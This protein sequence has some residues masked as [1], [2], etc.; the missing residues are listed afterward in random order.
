M[1][2]CGF[3]L[4]RQIRSIQV[5]SGGVYPGQSGDYIVVRS[6]IIKDVSFCGIGYLPWPFVLPA[7]G[8]GYYADTSKATGIRF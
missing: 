6:W 2:L 4:E 8:P 5:C 1:T 3:N 7:K